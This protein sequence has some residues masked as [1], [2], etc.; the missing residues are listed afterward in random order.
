VTLV[1]KAKLVAAA[2]KVLKV[3]NRL[4]TEVTKVVMVIKVLKVYNL[5]VNKVTKAVAAMKAAEVL[6]DLKVIKVL[7]VAAVTK[8][9]NLL[10]H[11]DQK[12]RLVIHQQEIED[13]KV[14]KVHMER[15]TQGL[16]V[17]KAL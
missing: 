16:L 11:V 6:K 17:I 2:K 4:V 3:Y 7:L 9:Y 10:L 8:V 14:L 5:E 1:K 15:T 13:K 12:V